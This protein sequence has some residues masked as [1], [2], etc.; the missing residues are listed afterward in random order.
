MFIQAIGRAIDLMMTSQFSDRIRRRGRARLLAAAILVSGSAGLAGCGSTLASM[1][2][3]GEPKNAP[4][5]PEGEQTYP[6][7]F[8]ATAKPAEE[9]MSAAERDK[10]KAD[11]IAARDG[12]AAHRRSEIGQADPPPPQPKAPARAKKQ[13]TSPPKCEKEACAR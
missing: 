8:V 7:P 11:L 4:P 3:I 5:R 6:V 10:L 1:P 13:A 9:K 12:A 2:L